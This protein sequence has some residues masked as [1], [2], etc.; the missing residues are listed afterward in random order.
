MDLHRPTLGGLAKS[1]C[2]EP[3]AAGA[4]AIARVRA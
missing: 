3:Y 1:R 4:D 2:F